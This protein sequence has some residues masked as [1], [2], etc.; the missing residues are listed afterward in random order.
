MT[1]PSVRVYPTPDALAAAAVERVVAAARAAVAERG[2]FVIALAGG[3]TP[4]RAYS[5]LARPEN[6]GRVDWPRALVFF[7]DER[8]VPLDD[9]RSNYAMAHRSLLAHVPLS[10]ERVFAV[11]TQ[12]GPGEAVAAA[13]AG[14]ISRELGLAPGAWIGERV[15]TG[16]EGARA[17]TESL[18]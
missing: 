16:D 5:L 11:P 12:I 7:G 10:P 17:L 13:Y 18:P 2:R 6:A 9:P 1:T 3:S 14:T 8:L 4:E 15:V